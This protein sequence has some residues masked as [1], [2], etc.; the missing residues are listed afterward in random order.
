MDAINDQELKALL[1]FLIVLS[2]NIEKLVAKGSLS[3][4]DLPG[5]YG[6]FS[7]ASPA[8]SG[9]KSLPSELSS[10]NDASISDLRAYVSANINSAVANPEIDGLINGGLSLAQELFD[11][12]ASIKAAKNPPAAAAPVAAPAS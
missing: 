11:F 8:L 3:L 1:N 5:L 7:A 2:A 12:V 6:A 9:L 10:L 4:L